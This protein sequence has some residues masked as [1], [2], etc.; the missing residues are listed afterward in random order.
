[1]R[2]APIEPLRGG[3]SNSAYATRFAGDH[4][5]AVL[6]VAPDPQARLLSY[7]KDLMRA[8]VEV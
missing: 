5:D 3:W 7:V 4:P 6:R 8:K 2:V 1:M